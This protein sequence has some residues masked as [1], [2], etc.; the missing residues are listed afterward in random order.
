MSGEMTRKFSQNCFKQW[1]VK[2]YFDKTQW[3]RQ[4][5]FMGGFIQ[6]HVVVISICI[7]C[8]LFVTSQFDV[9]FMFPNQRF[10]EICWHNMYILLYALPLFYM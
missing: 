7:W 3:R 8:A 5:I 9:I 10:R 4:K 6:W 1:E 2:L